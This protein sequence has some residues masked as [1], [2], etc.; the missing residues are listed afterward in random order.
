[1]SK[2]AK[3][4]FAAKLIGIIG[5]IACVV[6]CAAYCVL[7]LP[8]LVNFPFEWIYVIADAAALVVFVATA[9]I[10]SLVAYAMDKKE[11]RAAEA[12]ARA[13]AEA[14]AAA[15]AAEAAARAEAEAAFVPEYECCLDC[16][17]AETCDYLAEEKAK[18]VEAYLAKLSEEEV[19]EEEVVEL[20]E[21]EA[22]VA[23]KGCPMMAQAE[24]EEEAEEV[25]PREKITAEVRQAI[26]KA[27]VTV[28]ENA[29]KVVIP[30]AAACVA[31]VFVA[32]AKKNKKRKVELK[33]MKDQAKFRQDFYKWLG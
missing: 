14:I 16:D 27:I 19:A 10:L 2:S 20:A 18:F 32:A 9:V 8:E 33:R 3:L 6:G 23:K 30:V 31:T 4:R 13:E 7:T 26:D 29:V 28:K 17:F 11:I 1:M 12:A 24:G 21:E 25:T 15:E 22:P 5:C